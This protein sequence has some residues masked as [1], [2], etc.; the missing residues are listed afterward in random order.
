MIIDK[1]KLS[2]HT[3]KFNAKGSLELLNNYYPDYNLPDR[4]N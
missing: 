3:E 2:H 4:Y 1:Q